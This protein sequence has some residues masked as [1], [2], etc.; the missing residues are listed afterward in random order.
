LLY[1]ITNTNTVI[2][3]KTNA[4]VPKPKSTQ[5]GMPEFAKKNGKN[6]PTI[7]ADNVAPIASIRKRVGIL[8]DRRY[9]FKSKILV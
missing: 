3:Q 5:L 9:D 6:I 7:K 1:C 8:S 2:Q 4:I